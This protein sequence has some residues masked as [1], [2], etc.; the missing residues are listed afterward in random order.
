[1]VTFR[2][3]VQICK[4]LCQSVGPRELEAKRANKV[5]IALGGLLRLAHARED[6]LL[7]NAPAIILEY[8]KLLHER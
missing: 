6:I 7:D 5:A 4:S 2:T 3:V 1:M 8:L